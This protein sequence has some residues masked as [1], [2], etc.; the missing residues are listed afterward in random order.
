MRKDEFV[1][2]LSHKLAALG[3]PATQVSRLTHEIQDHWDDLAEEGR[4]RG[5][6]PDRF[7][8]ERIGTIESLVNAHSQA[9]RNAHWAGRHPI[10]S[11]GLLPP[12]ALLAWCLGWGLMAA[13]AGEL[14]GK[15]LGLQQPFWSTFLLVL[16]TA[17]VIQ[18]TGLF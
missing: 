13:G 17:K 18:Y 14:Y 1:R 3:W 16:I 6:I 4:N 15:L 2:K 10:L 9:M 8:S 12:V 7:A 5:L 11:F